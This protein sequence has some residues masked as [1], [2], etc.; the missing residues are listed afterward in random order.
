MTP[1]Y[2]VAAVPVHSCIMLESE[3]EAREFPRGRIELGFCKSCGFVSNTAFDSKA[4]DYSA[5][6]ED[7]QC[8]SPTFNA[9]AARLVRDLVDRYDLR[10]KDIL[11]IGCGKGD[12]LALLCEAGG[13]RGVGI[14]PACDP[15]RIEGA[16]AERITLVQDYYSERYGHY[17]GDAVICRHTLEHIYDTRRFIE[18]VRAGIGDRRDTIV[19]F[20]VPDA[21]IV[22]DN[23]VFW[24]V[25]YEHCSCFSPGSLARLF[26]S[27]RFDVLDLRLDFD[28]QYLLIEAR[29]AD[30]TSGAPHPLEETTAEGERRVEHFREGVARQRDGWLRRI[31]ALHEAGR[32]PVIWGSGSKCVAFL[33]T[34]GIDG[35]IECVV[36]INPRR[37]G[38]YIAGVAKKIMPPEFLREYRPGAIIVMNPIYRDEVAGMAGGM[39]LAAEILTV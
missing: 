9:F 17:T 12:F 5:L 26:R 36:D 18:T 13:N 33:T 1:F 27:C 39:G 6:Y 16:A 23:L 28:D 15:A 24:D 31:R 38:K 35:E 4:Q 20:E 21:G 8:F 22:L 7:Q 2:S 25:Y 37:H 19:F 14:D 34:L 10:G 29:P 3:R 32:R 30:G 11:E